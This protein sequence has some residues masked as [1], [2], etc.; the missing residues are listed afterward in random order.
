MINF[1]IKENVEK[2]QKRFHEKNERYKIFPKELLH[3]LGDDF[4]LAPATTHKNMHNAYPGG[5]VDHIFTITKYAVE[6][7]NL[8]PT[9]LRVDVQS[10]IKVCFLHQIGKTYLYK[11]C[12]SEWHRE[13]QGKMY[14]YVENLIAMRIGERSIFYC[15]K[16]CVD[17]TEEEYQAII[18]FDKPEDDQQSKWHSETLSVILR[19]AN[20]LAIIEEKDKDIWKK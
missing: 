7:N 11:L 6:I 19:Q 3:F 5:L 13:N 17:L 14:D 20:E 4:F 1:D 15:T 10:L 8:L 9:K 2:L 12:E 18:N 16:Y